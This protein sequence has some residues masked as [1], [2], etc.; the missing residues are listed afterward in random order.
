[1]HLSKDNHGQKHTSTVVDTTVCNTSPVLRDLFLGSLER[2]AHTRMR[3][4][5]SLIRMDM[6]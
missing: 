6:L 4:T 3:L 1:M 5:M 2:T